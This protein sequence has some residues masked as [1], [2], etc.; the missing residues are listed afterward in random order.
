MYQ[1]G[2]FVFAEI[3]GDPNRV[4]PDVKKATDRKTAPKSK[5]T[6]KGKRS[7][8]SKKAPNTKKKK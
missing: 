8:K 4:L 1:G 7:L 2:N 5:K 6:A 3:G